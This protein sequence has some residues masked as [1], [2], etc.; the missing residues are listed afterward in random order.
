LQ[1]QIKHGPSFA[2]LFLDLAPGE[3]VRT[4]AG[5]MVAMSDN[6]EIKTK[7]YGGV[8]KALLRKLFGGESVFQNTYTPKGGNGELILSPTM[9]G[10][11]RHV[12]ME[13][14]PFILQG[15]SFLASSPDVTM[16]TKY[17]GMKSMISGEG[18]FLLEINGT[19]DLWFNAYG[20]IVEVDVNGEYIVDTGHIVGFEN[21]LTFKVRKVGGLKSTILSGEGFVAAFS[22][23]GKLYIQSRTVS[24]LLGWITPMLPQ[25]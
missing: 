25:R 10:E 14:K 2:S 7:A 16:K 4:E 11:I 21:G 19:G 8:F 23:K 3:A 1:F 17:G 12:K 6:L 13:N 20:N 15:S 22:G 9:P 24:A 18:L 5:A